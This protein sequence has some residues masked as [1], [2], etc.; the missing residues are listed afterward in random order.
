VIGERKR[1]MIVNGRVYYKKAKSRL[2]FE[3]MQIF[4]VVW[5]SYFLCNEVRCEEG[6]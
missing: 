1:V 3:V 6:E 4:L 2:G 5:W